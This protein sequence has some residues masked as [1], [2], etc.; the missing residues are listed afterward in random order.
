MIHF[1]S[2]FVVT[3][4]SLVPLLAPASVLLPLA[5][6]CL[7]VPVS[8]MPGVRPADQQAAALHGARHQE[9]AAWRVSSRHV[10]D[11]GDVPLQ[12]ELQARADL[13]AQQGAVLQ[14]LQSG[15]QLVLR[16][17]QWAGLDPSQTKLHDCRRRERS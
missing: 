14:N 4:K 5:H 16:E 11:A 15:C 3:L 17:T 9:G 1:H 13:S 8:A 6:C 10:P 2:F 7:Q 12:P